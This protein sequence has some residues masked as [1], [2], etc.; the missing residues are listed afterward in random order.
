MVDA[1][2]D[3]M[4]D[5]H[6]GTAFDNADMG[7]LISPKQLQQVLGY[8]EIGRREGARLVTGGRRI[9]TAGLADG[10]FVEPTVFADVTPR[11]RIAQEEI[12]GPVLSVIAF[13]DA[14]E[15][16]RIANGT[17]YGLTA[18]VWTGIWAGPSASSGA[19]RLARSM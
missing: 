17:K 4:H 2:A 16:I 3:L 13:D 7:P 12:F 11:M 9:T 5:I 8:I 14:D 1:V 18:S 19:C 15:A 10:N 6:V